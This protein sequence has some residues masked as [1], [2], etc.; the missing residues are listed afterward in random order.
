MNFISS[1]TSK[2]RNQWICEKSEYDK[3]K[4]NLKKCT[5][6]FKFSSIE[7]IPNNFSKEY[8]KILLSNIADYLHISP[9]N[10]DKFVK[11]GLSPMLN[12]NGEIL[13]AYIYH[14]IDNGECRGIHFKN[15]YDSNYYVFENDYQ[16]F[17]VNNID[18]FG[19]YEYGSKDAVLVYKK[20]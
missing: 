2:L 13:A 16:V 14:F 3:T 10:F 17:K 9:I 18:D 1:H 19:T 20:S 11:N 5:I 7:N 4:E 6:N 15:S 12:V 8:D